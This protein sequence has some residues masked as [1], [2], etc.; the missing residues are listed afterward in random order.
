MLSAPNAVGKIELGLQKDLAQGL[1]P[2]T[3]PVKVSFDDYFQATG[4]RKDHQWCKSQRRRDPEAQIE[5]SPAGS[6]WLL[7]L[8]NRK[9]GAS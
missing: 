8:P 1:D 9:E 2:S 6:E 4:K 5:Q 7:T 3:S